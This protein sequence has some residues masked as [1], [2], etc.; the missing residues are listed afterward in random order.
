MTTH[1]RS[2]YRHSKKNK[3]TYAK[4]FVAV[5]LLAGII[6]LLYFGLQYFSFGSNQVSGAFLHTD[7]PEQVSILI[8]G[9][10]KQNVNEIKVYENNTIK[11]NNGYAKLEFTN[12]DVIYIDQNS[13]VEIVQNSR[14]DTNQ[15]VSITLSEGAMYIKSAKQTLET[16]RIIQ[17]ELGTITIPNETEAILTTH[18]VSVYNDNSAGT[19]V[20]TPIMTTPLIIGEL[21]V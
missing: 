13:L 1:Y 17:T 5:A 11:T 9:E 18:S 21:I 20:F 4:F 2:T 10:W 6:W 7:T 8:D 16:S 19:E 3:A 14:S 12:Q 15:T